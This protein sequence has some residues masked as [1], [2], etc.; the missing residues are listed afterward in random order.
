[1]DWCG[2][3]AYVEDMHAYIGEK[4]TSDMLLME[5]ITIGENFSIN[6]MQSGQG[7]LY[8]DALLAQ[9]HAL[10]IPADLVGEE[11]YTLCDTQIPE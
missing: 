10:D 1:M 9:L 7:K 8:V 4:H 2:M 3:D 5:I 6:V 11:R